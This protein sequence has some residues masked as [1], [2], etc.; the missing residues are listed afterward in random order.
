MGEYA[1][2]TFPVH[3]ADEA[4]FWLQGFAIGPLVLAPVTEEYGRYWAYVGSVASYTL[5]LLTQSL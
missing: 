1:D 5:L 3:D 2:L 4:H